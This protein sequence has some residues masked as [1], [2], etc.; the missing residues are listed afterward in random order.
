MGE[1]GTKIRMGPCKV[2]FGDEFE[3]NKTI[4]GVDFSAQPMLHDISVDQYGQG[5]YDKRI[6]GWEVSAVIRMAE[7]DYDTIKEISVGLEEIEGAGEKKKLVDKALGTSMRTL[8]KKL[9]IHPLDMGESVAEDIVIYLAAPDTPVDL[10]FNYENERVLEVT[11][12]GYPLD[13]ESDPSAEPG[14]PNV[15]FCIGDES[16]EPVS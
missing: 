11:M 3:I 8:A 2:T 9:T 14:D 4:G 10:K 5:V 7:T 16:A 15:Y 13:E 6:V 1:T 12:I